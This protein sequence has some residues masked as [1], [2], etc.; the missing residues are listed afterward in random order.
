MDVKYWNEVAEHYDRDIF[1]VLANDKK[2]LLSSRIHTFGSDE[3]TASDL[4][5]GIGKFLPMLSEN[6]GHVYAYDISETCL[7]QAR[8]HCAELSNVEFIR[9]DLSAGKQRMPKVDFILCVNSLIMPSMS[10]RAQYLKLIRT[11]LKQKGHLLLVVPSLESAL[12][13]RLRLIEW[14]VR[15]GL[16]YGTAVT[17]GVNGSRNPNASRL[18]Q[19]IINLEHVPTKH[20]L[21]EELY[22]TL[23][24]LGFEL[25]EI[26]KIEY[27]WKT[28]FSHPPRW[29]KAPFPWDWLVTARIC[30]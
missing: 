11:H 20:Y 2:N 23:G 9:T 24:D 13:S 7:R 4:G 3:K 5:T 29:M 6:F 28:E 30:K 1:D 17:A 19:G 22:S 15:R 16:S 12:Y 18:Q 8:E 27:G 10:Q 21:E 14:N 25:C 26:V